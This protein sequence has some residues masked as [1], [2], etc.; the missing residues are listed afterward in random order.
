[1]SFALE[2]LLDGV[3][4]SRKRFWKHVN[5]LTPEQWDWKP[6]PECKSARETLAHLIWVDR[7]A[8]VS[9]ETGGEPDYAALEEAER[10]FE[11]L[12]A[13][14][15]ETHARLLDFL[16][17]RYGDQPLDTE[18]CLFGD[19]MKLGRAAAY[20]SGEDFYHSGQ[21]AYIRMATDPSWNYYDEIYG[22]E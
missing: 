14:L 17:A 4:A 12:R 11:R 8:L 21:V 13:M 18:V 2:D 1:M 9:L 20:L 3:R 10:D 7:I 6:F 19:T 5:G 15:L 16:T 22:G